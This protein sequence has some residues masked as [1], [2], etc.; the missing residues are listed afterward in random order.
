MSESI[1]LEITEGVAIITWRVLRNLTPSTI[2]WSSYLVDMQTPSM[3][4]DPCER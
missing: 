2:R 3:P 4:I 1:R